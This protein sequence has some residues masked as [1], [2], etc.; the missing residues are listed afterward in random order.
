MSI[1]AETDLLSMNEGRGDAMRADDNDELAMQLMADGVPL[2]LLVDIALPMTLIRELFSG[3]DR[4][5]HS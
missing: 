2:Q 5:V 1:I 3:P 4:A